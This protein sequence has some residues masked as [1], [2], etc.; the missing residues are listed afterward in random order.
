MTQAN[1][2]DAQESLGQGELRVSHISAFSFSMCLLE[3]S[4]KCVQW[5]LAQFS[6]QIK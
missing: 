4:L 2:G 3:S 6:I 5:V 1:F